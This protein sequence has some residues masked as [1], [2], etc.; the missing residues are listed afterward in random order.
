M[1]I[2]LIEDDEDKTR[3]I[4]DF[5]L[6]LYGNPIVVEAKSFSSGLRQ[7]IKL[8]SELDV[9]LLDMS[10]PNYDVTFEE[11]SGGTPEPFAGRAL[12]AQMQLRDVRIPVI[13]VTMFDSF[14]ENEMKISLP[15]LKEDLKRRY[16][17]PYLDTVY[18]DARQEG[19]RNELKNSLLQLGKTNE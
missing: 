17:P 18:Y 10:M 2:L 12:L 8:T 7:A 9:I 13:I 3:K 19:W 15:Q 1:R 5:L 14:G 16:S 11:P 6:E 4:I